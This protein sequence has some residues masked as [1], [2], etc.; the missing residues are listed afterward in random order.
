[1]S[2]NHTG[3]A[4]TFYPTILMPED[5]DPK[6]ITPIRSVMN[7]LL[8]NDAYLKG[9][10]TSRRAWRSVQLRTLTRAGTTI[11]DTTESLAAIQLGKLTLV[12]KANSG[13]ILKA[14]D[15]VDRYAL[16]GALTSVT[17]LVRDVAT[18]GGALIAIG[19]GGNGNCSSGDDGATWS[20]G[21]GGA[22]AIVAAAARARIVADP[23]SSRFIVAGPGNTNAYNSIDGTTW[24]ARAMGV[25]TGSAGL[26]Q[27]PFQTV[28]LSEGANTLRH[29]TDGGTTWAAMTG[30]PANSGT[31]DES[32]CIIGDYG[33]SLVWHAAR[34][35][36]G[37]SLQI[38]S[39]T[40]VGAASTWT[41]RA[42]ITATSLGLSDFS[43]RPRVFCCPDT[44]LLV[45]VG[46][47]NGGS[48]AY[49]VAS[50]DNGVTWGRAA[51]LLPGGDYPIDTFAVA[52]GR[53]F[54]TT[55]AQVFASDGSEA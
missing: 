29:S 32:G 26:S 39:A 41:T 5:G 34:K 27:T 37:A 38:S 24:T 53:L 18:Y 50:I 33:N 8:D 4:T 31:F 22:V 7:Q 45:V 20:A 47:A 44:G 13:G 25:A 2:S 15:G 17:S 43:A 42:T 28:A 11:D 52:G 48:V 36:T 23:D 46:Q 6:T 1:M 54:A 35:S 55:D 40:L 3:D 21:G 19:S 14:T 49:A 12:L 16:A 9:A 51:L 30:F 10:D